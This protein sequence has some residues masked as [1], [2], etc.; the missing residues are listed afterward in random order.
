MT[1]WISNQFG[2]ACM[3]CATW[4]QGSLRCL[5]N[6]NMNYCWPWVGG[7]VE[8]DRNVMWLIKIPGWKKKAILCCYA[9][10]SSS[11]HCSISILWTLWTPRM[12]LQSYPPVL[13]N[14]ILMG[15]KSPETCLLPPLPCGGS[16]LSFSNMLKT[17]NRW[18]SHWL[19]AN[20]A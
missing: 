19:V 20:W 8:Q 15:N 4:G 1:R 14:Q 13:L 16:V 5:C 10:I 6:L 17:L 18:K 11:L 9:M 2:M 12:I 3:V 7:G